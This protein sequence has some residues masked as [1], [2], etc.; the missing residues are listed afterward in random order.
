MP[1]DYPKLKCPD[2]QDFVR[3]FIRI[4]VFD[5]IYRL[6]TMQT[7]TQE[8]SIIPDKYVSGIP[9]THTQGSQMFCKYSPKSLVDIGF[10]SQE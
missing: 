8:A 6:F 5:L 9:W 10:G 7:R 3:K 2:T 4:T 1:Q